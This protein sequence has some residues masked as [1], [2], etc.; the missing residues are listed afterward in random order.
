PGTNFV[1]S[2]TVQNSGTCVWDDTYKMVFDSGERLTPQ[3]SFPV[4]PKGYTVKSGESLTINI[5]MTAPSAPGAYESTFKLVD[6]GGNHVF[7]VGVLTNVGTPTNSSLA[8]PGDLRY[9]YDCS[10]GITR[11]S[12]TWKDKAD[13]EEGYRIYRDGEKLTDLPA[14]STVYDDIAPS[15]GSYQYTV[16]AYNEGGESPTKVQAE[17]S[18]C[19]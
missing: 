12:L 9:T 10:G 2:W 4:M 14:G 15:P 1:M 11:I 19:Q 17:T 6:A 16:A 18:N 7:I 3:D 13:G 8:A 5:Q